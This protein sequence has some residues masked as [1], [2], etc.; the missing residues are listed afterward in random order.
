MILF[1]PIVT[2]KT[3]E[4]V[5]GAGNFPNRFAPL[6]TSVEMTL[7]LATDSRPKGQN[8]EYHAE[9]TSTKICSA[10]NF[11][12][13]NQQQS[14]VGMNSLPKADTT[15]PL[16]PAQN[17]NQEMKSEW[18]ILTPA[19]KA[20][21]ALETCVEAAHTENSHRNNKIPACQSMAAAMVKAAD[22]TPEKPMCALRNSMAFLDTSNQKTVPM[23]RD[24]AA[25]WA[26]A[27]VE[28]QQGQVGSNGTSVWSLNRLEWWRKNGKPHTKQLLGITLAE[29]KGDGVPDP[30][31]EEEARNSEE[32]MIAIEPI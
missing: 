17:G 8:K 27:T 13:V 10:E 12:A 3:V 26:K 22:K 6:S 30:L 9:E 31:K 24:S 25:A 4:D 29:S 20:W 19:H 32:P 21:L 7:P 18:I 28:L 1:E 2:F 23:G 5:N 16:L 15:P 14:A 11:L